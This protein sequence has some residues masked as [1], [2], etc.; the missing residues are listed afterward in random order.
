MIFIADDPVVGLQGSALGVDGGVSTMG[1]GTY[2]KQLK[3]NLI[4][5]AGKNHL[6]IDS[7]NVIC[8]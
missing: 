3:K 4:L 5:V 6:C 1:V 2:R 7:I 8:V